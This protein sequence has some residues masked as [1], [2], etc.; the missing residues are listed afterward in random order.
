MVVTYRNGGGWD[1]VVDQADA[2]R[3]LVCIQARIEQRC[4]V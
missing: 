2:C 4:Q 3:Q 1:A